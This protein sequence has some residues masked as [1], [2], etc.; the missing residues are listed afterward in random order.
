M[1]EAPGVVICENADKSDGFGDRT[2]GGKYAQAHK[3]AQRD[4]GSLAHLQL[5]NYEYWY[6]G[7]DKIRQNVGTE[8]NVPGQDGSVGGHASALYLWVPQ[9]SQ[10]YAVEEEHHSQSQVGDDDEG[11]QEPEEA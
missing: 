9:L 4:F 6:T 8:S 3:T 1:G 10:W 5:M 7:T 11:Y 2:A